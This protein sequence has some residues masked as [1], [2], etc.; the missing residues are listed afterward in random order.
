MHC[1]IVANLMFQGTHPLFVI[2]RFKSRLKW[3]ERDQ[4]DPEHVRQKIEIATVL[5]EEEA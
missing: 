3:S 1:R 2:E 5:K 4:T